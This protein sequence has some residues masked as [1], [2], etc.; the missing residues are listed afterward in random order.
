MQFFQKSH[1]EEI[2]KASNVMVLVS[3]FEFKKDKTSFKLA[4]ETE[5]GRQCPV[6]MD[7]RKVISNIRGFSHMNP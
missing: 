2:Q 7:A 4:A 6:K 1:H 5:Q 3:L